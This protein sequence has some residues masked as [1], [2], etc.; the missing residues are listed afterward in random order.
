MI[1]KQRDPTLEASIYDPETKICHLGS[2]LSKPPET[3]LKNSTDIISFISTTDTFNKG[4]KIQCHLL[5]LS[6]YN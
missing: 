3:A 6:K 2:V 5:T 1:A 4:G